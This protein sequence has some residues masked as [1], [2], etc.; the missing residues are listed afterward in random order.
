MRRIEDVKTV[1]TS[2]RCIKNISSFSEARGELLDLW[3]FFSNTLESNRIK[4]K[5]IICFVSSV[6]REKDY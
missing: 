1:I 2:F 4:A 3:D 5:E 6:H